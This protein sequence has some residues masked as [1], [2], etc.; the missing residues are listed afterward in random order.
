MAI[1]VR[2]GWIGNCI[3]S[4]YC[5]T[6][7]MEKMMARVLAEIKAEIRRPRRKEGKAESHDTEQPRKMDTILKE[8]RPGMNT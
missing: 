5:H 6:M 2:S 1:G 3:G 4:F 8:I 7:E